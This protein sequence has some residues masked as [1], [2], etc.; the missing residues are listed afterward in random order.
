M[1]D[2]NPI[3]SCYDDD[4]VYVPNSI[5]A[6]DYPFNETFF[7]DNCGVTDFVWTMSGATTRSSSSSGI[8]LL[9]EQRLN[10]GTTTI[11]LTVRDQE[12]N[13]T[14]CSFSIKVQQ[15]DDP[16]VNC[17]GDIYLG[18]NP[19]DFLSNIDQL[20]YVEGNWELYSV[21]SV[22]GNEISDS[23]L[24]CFFE[25]TRTY[26]VRFRL[27]FFIW[28]Y[29]KEIT[30]T[31]TYTYKKDIEAP[32]LLG[33]PNDLT[34]E[35]NNIPTAP[36]VTVSDNCDSGASLNYSESSTQNPDVNHPGHYNYLLTRTWEAT[37]N[38][39]NVTS[40][41]QVITVRD[42]QAPKIECSGDIEESAGSGSCTRQ[43]TLPDPL[44]SDNGKLKKVD[45]EVDGTDRSEFSNVRY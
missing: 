45:L 25:R 1:D 18:C 28:W 32:T 12:G 22:L 4:L 37:D 11:Q 26:T 21:S 40:K 38:C 8:N 19:S 42:T 3:I 16:A 14:S 10:V 13:S 36:T 17:P 35:Y 31:R 20:T 29:Y 23:G 34:V 30:C 15:V 7:D 33:V 5:S 43:L 2:E 44:V 41:S 24:G 27:Q 9:G 6:I 39:G